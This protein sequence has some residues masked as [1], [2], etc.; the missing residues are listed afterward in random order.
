MGKSNCTYHNYNYLQG[1]TQV[2]MNSAR[3]VQ[4]LGVTSVRMYRLHYF[5][6]IISPK[7][8]HLSTCSRT[9]SIIGMAT[10]PVP[11]QSTAVKLL[12]MSKAKNDLKKFAKCESLR[13][14]HGIL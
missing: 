7:I 5:V 6:C 3:Q 2:E 14:V 11:K 9:L 8:N 10:M 12:A 13:D 4:G 1:V